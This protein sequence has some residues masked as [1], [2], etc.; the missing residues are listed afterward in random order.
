M[1]GRRRE[2][3]TLARRIFQQIFR[4][5]QKWSGGYCD[6]Y[7]EAKNGQ[8]DILNDIRKKAKNGQENILTE[9]KNGFRQCKNG[10]AKNVFC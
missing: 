6:Q 2:S 10:G 7:S 1:E 8:E 3:H 4:G 5:G 9:A